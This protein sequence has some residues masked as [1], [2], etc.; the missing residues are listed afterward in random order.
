M[1]A[2][3]IL[4]MAIVMGL[5]TTF[6][7]YNHMGNYN[8][9]T[10]LSENTVK[11]VVAN[12]EIKQN[13]KI[14]ADM[15]SHENVPEASVHPES[16]KSISDLENN[17]ST[18]K[19]AK[20]EVFLKHNA[21]TTTEESL[22]VSRKV[23]EQFRAVSVGV[24]FV[25]SVSNLIEPEDYVDVFASTKTTDGNKIETILLSENVRVLAIG[26]KMIEPVEGEPYVE[27][28]SVTLELF[29]DD[30]LKLV[31]AEENGNI[32]LAVRSKLK[33]KK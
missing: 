15:L 13:E 19:M 31:H 16:V 10:V 14:T 18:T 9:A 30:V 21:R 25:Q 11:V 6:L 27:Y 12:R 23:K 2:K 26:R 28:S 17:Y 20:G 29:P 7:F 8:A 3:L 1:R 32:H 24:N 33:T 4:G 5:I 22:R